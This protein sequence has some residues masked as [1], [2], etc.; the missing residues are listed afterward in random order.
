MATAKRKQPAQPAQPTQPTNNHQHTTSLW[1]AFKESVFHLFGAWNTSMRTVEKTVQLAENE[2]DMLNGE[3]KLR[4][5]RI[6]HEREVQAA[7]LAAS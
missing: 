7:L 4:L 3:Q 2:V 6:K 5:D 1:S